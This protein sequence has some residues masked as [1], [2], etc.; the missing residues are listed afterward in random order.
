MLAW[1]L[2]ELALNNFDPRGAHKPE[3]IFRYFDVLLRI[4][5][6]IFGDRTV[7]LLQNDACDLVRRCYL[8][9]HLVYTVRDSVRDPSQHDIPWHRGNCIRC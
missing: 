6:N 2:A 9:H 4:F 7:L 3:P 1:L 8:Q 5:E